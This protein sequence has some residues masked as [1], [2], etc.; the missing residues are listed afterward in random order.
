MNRHRDIEHA[1][2]LRQRAAALRGQADAADHEANA[3]ELAALCVHEFEDWS[4]VNVQTMNVCRYCGLV[5]GTAMRVG[6]TVAEF[7]D[8][9]SKFRKS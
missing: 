7:Q 8:Y 5:Q 3:M 1:V 6:R 4:N 2:A 9:M